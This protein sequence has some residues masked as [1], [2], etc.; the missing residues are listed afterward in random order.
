[1]S[2]ID[3]GISLPANVYY[4]SR[5]DEKRPLLAFSGGFDS[6]AM[7]LK[8]TDEG[9]ADIVSIIL[10]NNRDKNICER[11]AQKAIIDKLRSRWIKEEENLPYE[12]KT[13]GN[14]CIHYFSHVGVSQQKFG[15]SQ[16]PRWLIGLMDVVDPRMHNAV[17]IGYVSGD[18]ATGV[19]SELKSAWHYLWEAVFPGDPLVPLV[20]PM[21]FRTKQELLKK[22]PKDIY[23]L[24]WSCETPRELTPGNKETGEEPTF[25]KCDCCPACERRASEYLMHR[26]T[27]RRA[28][29]RIRGQEKDVYEKGNAIFGVNLSPDKAAPVT[30]G[31][32]AK[33]I[34]NLDSDPSDDFQNWPEQETPPDTRHHLDRKNGIVV[35]T[36]LIDAD[37]SI[38]A[39]DAHDL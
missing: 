26:L 12:K 9:R 18:Q 17:M 24:T 8:F 21:A 35:P 25:D 37:P 13:N 29:T 20:F 34:T 36:R 16:M 6:T 22:M 3:T 31:Q 5:T 33:L 2:Y 28:Q 38:V 30:D 10:A 4:A 7:L 14:I 1:M 32:L 15:F 39:Q 19:T 27:E 23:D 11:K